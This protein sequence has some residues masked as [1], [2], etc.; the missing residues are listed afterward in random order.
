[1]R[2]KSTD[3][4]K[5]APAPGKRKLTD[6]FISS[7]K[8]KKAPDG[9]R[10]DYWDEITRNF[11][12]RLTDGGVAT[13]VLYLRWPGSSVAARRMIDRVEDTTLAKA[14]E[15]AD[16]WRKLVKQGTDPKKKEHE[17]RVKL[18]QEQQ[19]TFG[20]VAEAWL[21]DG[22]R[23]QRKAAEV[24]TDVRREFKKPW[25]KRPI[26]SITTADVASIIK[27]KAAKGHPAQARNLLGYVKRLFD[28]A[29]DQHAYGIEKSPAEPLRAVRL[30]G[31]KN[32]RRRVLTDDELRAV[33]AAAEQ[34]EY[35][36]GPIFRMLIL[37]GQRKSEVGDAR[38]S[39]F[40]LNRK[41]WII[42]A[43]RMK[44]DE[45]HVVPLAADVIALLSELP[46]FK[47]GDCLF[48]THFGAKPCNG[49]SKAK[50]RLDE[51]TGE[52]EHWVIHDL[53]RTMRTGLSALPIPDNVR[54][55]MIAHAQP[56][57]KKTYD[58]YAY[59]E[60]KR[61]GFG[62]WEAHLRGILQQLDKVVAL[63]G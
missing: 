41:L 13:Y 28:W 31:K 54:E 3:K 53:R 21:A 48:S 26:T 11:G 52:L 44:M 46:R 32:I 1:M 58:R 49:Y 47:D 37:T 22:I 62:L 8:N 40:D 61:R 50:E 43:E 59:I 36:Y 60:E 39:E 7:L 6:K 18:Q 12:V 42:P 57:L 9:K 33:W 56:G 55:L 63:R 29:V 24:R 16:E 14:R 23:G 19:T 34:T 35:P 5:P 17:N 51:L 20:V 2:K 25:E 45:A 30:V 27:A 4:L 15:T 38:W 10:I